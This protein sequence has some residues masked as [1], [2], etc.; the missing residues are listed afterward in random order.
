MSEPM[1]Q[2]S[3]AEIEKF[4]KLAKAS[5]KAIELLPEQAIN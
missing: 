5:H 3:A 4:I 1:C 2:V